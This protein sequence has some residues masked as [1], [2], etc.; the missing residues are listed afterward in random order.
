MKTAIQI[1]NSSLF[2]WINKYVENLKEKM[3]KYTAKA[4]RGVYTMI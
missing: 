3:L 4:H 1:M 2:F